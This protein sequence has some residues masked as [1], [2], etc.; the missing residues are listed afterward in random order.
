MNRNL[1]FEKA[2]SL[3]IHPCSL[4]ALG[5]MLANDFVFRRFSPSWLTG[6]ISDLA[7]LFFVP[8]IAAALLAWL[9][10]GQKHSP[11]H[12]NWTFALAF[13]MTGCGYLLVKTLPAVNGLATRIFA[14]VLQANPSLA[15]DPS[16]LLALPALALSAWLWRSSRSTAQAQ[17]ALPFSISIR[18]LVMLPAAALILLA[19]AA[20]PDPGITCIAQQG[21]TLV[22]RGGYDS[23][24]T[25][26]DGGITWSPAAPGTTTTVACEKK[27]VLA[28]DGEWMEAPGAQAGIRYR[29]LQN[30]EVQ[31]SADGGQ[32]WKTGIVLNKISEPEQYYY[33]KSRSGSPEMNPGPYDAVAD[34][35]T[36][37]MLFAMGQQGILVHTA[38]GSWVWSQGGTYQRPENFPSADAL[39]LL[40]GGMGL[41]A[42]GAALLVYCTL[43]LRWT[44]HWVR[45]VVVITAWL[46]WLGLVILF[47]PATSYSYTESI[48]WMGILAVAVLIIPLTVEQTIRM[49]NRAPGQIVRLL[50]VGLAGGLLFLAP[51]FFWVYNALPDYNW[52]ILISVVLVLAVLAAGQISLRAAL[53]SITQQA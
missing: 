13:G 20:A 7:W 30:E 24:F 26:T 49:V 46:G 32:T 50:L 16:D 29:Y 10:P 2:F 37:N 47:P 25:S 21:S 4:V 6:K 12:Q 19:D 27:S 8:F 33:L 9:I 17:N 11:R 52:A 22:A 39:L 43:A 31:I 42:F 5:L 38:Q 3:I 1:T 41:M 45:I 35:A 51:Y 44:K 28:G 34:P 40:L 18:G 15:L 23:T 14:M 53:S 48:T 36:G